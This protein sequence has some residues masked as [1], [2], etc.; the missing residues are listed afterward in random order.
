[1]A[2]SRPHYT[3]SGAR[4]SNAGDRYHLVYVARRLLDLLHPYS[5]LTQLVIENVA[6]VDAATQRDPTAFLGADV[7]EYAGGEDVKTAVAVAVVQVKYSSLRPERAWTRSRLTERKKRGEPVFRKL[8]AMFDALAPSADASAPHARVTVRLLTNQPLGPQLRQDLEALRATIEGKRPRTAGRALTAVCGR[9]GQTAKALKEASGLPWPRLGEFLAAWDLDAFG[10]PS[11]ARTEAELFEALSGFSRDGNER[12]EVLLSSLQLRATPGQRETL[13]RADVL[14]FLRL[15]EDEFY[16]APSV[17]QDQE[18]LFDTCSVIEVRQAIEQEDGKVV[19]HGSSGSGKTS[20]LRLALGVQRDEGKAVVY[21]CFADGQGLLPGNERFPYKKCFTQVINELEARYRTDILATVSL[22]YQGLM[23]QLRRS[24]EAAARVAK[25]EGHRLVL[26]FDAIDNASEQKRRAPADAGESFVPMLWTLPTP[27]NCTLVVSLRTENLPEVVADNISDA[28]RVEVRGFNQEETRRH[29]TCLAPS[30]LPEEILFLHERTAGNPRVQSKLLKEIASHPSEEAR[31]LID[32]TARRTAFDY[33]D[34]ESKRRLASPDVR[35]VLAVLYE[36]RQAPKLADVSAIT[37]LGEKEL[38]KILDRLSFGLCRRSEERVAWQ[39]Q[40]F[41]DWTGE[42]LETERETAR[43]TLADYC[44]TKFERDEYA[45]WNLSHHLFQA[46]QFERLVAWWREPG[47]LDEQIR[48]AHPHE[49]QV[50]EDLRAAILSALRIGQTS[51]AFDLLLRAADIA[52]GRDAFADA[53]AEH[54]DVAV[55]ADLAHVLPGGPGDEDK[56]SGVRGAT[57]EVSLTIAA[58]LATRP[59]DRETARSLFAR[60]KA[61]KQAERVKDPEHGGRLS[62][63]EFSVYARYEARVRGFCAAL[64]LLKDWESDSWSRLFA[65]TVGAH[66]LTTSENDPLGAIS[67]AS[68]GTGE[69]A[70]ASLGVLAALD[71]ERARE[72]ALKRLDRG[73][74]NAAVELVAQALVPGSP[75]PAAV[76]QKD[77][78]EQ[79]ASHGWLVYALR[80]AIENLT[81]AGLLEAACELLASWS[82]SQPQYRTSE[83]LEL[84][85]RWA[86]L[87]EALTDTVFDPACYELSPGSSRPKADDSS[88]RD[89]IRREMALAYPHLR[90]RALAWVGASAEDL[91]T[92]VRQL[93]PAWRTNRGNI[94][95]RVGWRYQWNTAILLEAV[96]ALPENHLPLVREIVEAAAGLGDFQRLARVAGADVLSRDERYLGEVE[97]LILKELDRCRPPEVPAREGME[98]LL[99]FYKP[100]A[101]VSASLARR[102]IVAARETASQIDSRIYG[103]AEALTAIAELAL[104]NLAPERLDELCAVTRYWWSIDLESSQNAGKRALALLAQKD[105]GTALKRAWDLDQRGLL[106]FED[107]LGHVAAGAL[108]GRSLL[109][110]VVWPIVPLLT[111]SNLLNAVARSSIELLHERGLSVESALRTYCRLAILNATNNRP[112]GAGR[113]IVEWAK[114]AGFSSFSEIRTTQAFVERLTA[115]LAEQEQS[116]HTAQARDT[117]SLTRESQELKDRANPNSLSE[118][119]SEKIP[120]SPRTALARLEEAT[121]E[122]LKA[123]TFWEF[124]DLITSF[125]KALPLSDRS[126]LACEIERWVA[127]DGDGYYATE[128]LPLFNI[129]LEDGAAEEPDLVQAVGD[130]V[131]RLL[132]ADNLTSLASPYHRD[133]LTSLLQQGLWGIATARL[134]TCLGA[135]AEHLREIGSDAL[136]SLSAKMATL[137]EPLDLAVVA[138]DFISRTVSKVPDLGDPMLPAEELAR[139]IPSALILALGHPRQ[140]LRWRG[141]YAVVHALVDNDKPE[142]FLGPLL[143]ALDSTYSPRWL[144]VREWLA[145]A[146][147]HVALRKPG[148]LRNAVARLVPHAVSRELPHAKIRHHLKQ[149]LLAI[150]KSFPGSLSSDELATLERVNRPVAIVQERATPSTLSLYDRELWSTEDTDRITPDP[151]D[152]VRYWYQPLARCFAGED[153]ERSVVRRAADWMARLGITRS[154]VEDERSQLGDRYDYGQMNNDHGSQPMVELLRL[155]GERHGLY[156]AAGELIDSVPVL[157]TT[158]TDGTGNKWDDWARYKLRGADPALPSRLVDAPPPLADNYGVFSSPVDLWRKKEEPDAFSRELEVPSEPGWVVVAQNRDG[159]DYDRSFS[160]TVNSALVS[161]TAAGA[162]AR[163][164]ESESREAF[165]P[166]IEL[167]YDSTLPE[168]EAEMAEEAAYRHEGIRGEHDAGNGRFVLKAWIVWFYQE[169]SLHSVDPWWPV[170][171]RN[172]VLPAL[173]VVHRFGWIRHPTELLWRDANGQSVARCDLWRRSDDTGNRNY[174]GCRLVMRHEVVSSYAREVGLDVIFAVRL[175]RQGRSDYRGGGR[176]EYDPGTTRCFLWSEVS[177]IDRTGGS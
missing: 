143:D 92:E 145:F 158:W 125:L 79:S 98:S 110:E 4:P 168:L 32:E 47:R 132:T 84:H 172:Y 44:L 141:V 124:R 31:R 19:V 120:Y 152:T 53:L 116:R 39:D 58:E 27:K 8:T 155:Y 80:D 148:V 51:Q 18:S 74:V 35:R 59:R 64:D 101:R 45:R 173:D 166:S 113:D 66:W 175:S 114:S 160:A 87:W 3:E 107:G 123:V 48:A 22:D 17:F 108:V 62:R 70:A 30:L 109:P 164:R 95:S 42:R 9:A 13:R 56:P 165:L 72:S 170:T 121:V 94:E 118:A 82:P 36:M 11:L 111:D 144:S 29:A 83:N 10:H 34:Q 14:A 133:A 89:A 136:F 46:R 99:S 96:L 93:I 147:E 60:F 104:P 50:L 69:R 153:I 150:E 2:E 130:S 55:A 112:V 85:L 54:P 102:V 67:L 41:L 138:R 6:P 100:A 73:A 119:L 23:R 68:L 86:A 40:D 76:F 61:A 37:D 78:G 137:L 163:L 115:V 21:D 157:E 57:T 20:A 149:V 38:G 81:A 167:P 12:L 106:D 33:Y 77:I 135:A 103:R 65:Y 71:S 171:G 128:A 52:E 63:D 146:F 88:E 134:D 159:F 122:E 43:A 90:V 142:S 75:N 154:A 91:P 161:P 15:R 176:E 105:P 174:E 162:L 129:I 1:M 117:T 25:Q 5:G 151:M 24:L 131:H 28:R 177:K 140:A 139:V 127:A 49:E 16:P 156:L 26:A 169:A 7:T 97:R 126:R